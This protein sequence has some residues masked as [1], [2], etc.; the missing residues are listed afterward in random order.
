M[1]FNYM[2]KVFNMFKWF[3]DTGDNAWFYY[4]YVGGQPT[5]NSNCRL[6]EGPLLFGWGVCQGYT[7]AMLI[8]C[9]LEGIESYVRKSSL[10]YGDDVHI[11]LLVKGSDDLFYL[12][13]PHEVVGIDIDI[14]FVTAMMTLSENVS[15][16]STKSLYSWVNESNDVSSFYKNLRYE[17]K[18][19]YITSVEELEALLTYL[20]SRGDYS[21]YLSIFYPTSL[22]NTFKSL[23]Q[24]K[25][26]FYERDGLESGSASSNIKNMIIKL[27]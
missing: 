2:Q 26:N 12:S 19:V 25:G 8:L 23:V 15:F 18:S 27:W 21:K 11:D 22:K 13:N 4:Q 20:N 9:R 6:A 14:F 16:Q 5:F 17:G 3:G 7:R 24:S 1:K 10:V